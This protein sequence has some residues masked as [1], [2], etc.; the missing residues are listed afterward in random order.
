MNTQKKNGK[1]KRIFTRIR[2]SV[3]GL[4]VKPSPDLNK[5][6]H[7]RETFIYG[8]NKTIHNGGEV[9]V[10][11][12]NGKVVAVW[13][14]CVHLPFTESEAGEARAADMRR[15]YEKPAPKVVSVELEKQK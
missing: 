2:S 3:T 12:H 9:N 15:L 1:I 4:F 14:R 7:Q 13:F 5:N 6:E 10:E 8:R 11:I